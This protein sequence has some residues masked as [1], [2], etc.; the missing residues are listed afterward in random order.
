MF[1]FLGTLTKYGFY[2]ATAV[3]VGGLAF[4]YATK[5]PADTLQTQLASEAQITPSQTLNNL[6]LNVATNTDSKDFV[7]FRLSAISIAGNQRKKFI[8]IG[9]VN[10]WWQIGR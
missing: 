8:Y 4:L 9:A 5:P 3:T 7:F 6:I 2:S 10:Y 1:A